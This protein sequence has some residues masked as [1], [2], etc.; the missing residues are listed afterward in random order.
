VDDVVGM[1]P[2]ARADGLR[3]SLHR[4]L[5]RMQHDFSAHVPHFWSSARHD[6]LAVTLAD[7]EARVRAGDVAVR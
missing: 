3:V 2:F 1:I 5:T 7:V 6:V 4:I